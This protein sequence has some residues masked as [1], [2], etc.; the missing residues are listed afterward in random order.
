MLNQLKLIFFNFFRNITKSDDE[1]K[2]VKNILKNS[3][4]IL[5]NS[6]SDEDEIDANELFE[7]NESEVKYELSKSS[8]LKENDS[9]EETEENKKKRTYKNLRKG[10]F[11]Y[12][13][14]F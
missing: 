8:N 7:E 1:K 9:E 6:S 4:E 2:L 3:T 11:Y 10:M 13:C 12:N 5:E 14:L